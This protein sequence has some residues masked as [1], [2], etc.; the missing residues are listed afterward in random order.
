MLPWKYGMRSVAV[1]A[2]TN[3]LAPCELKLEGKG[4]FGSNKLLN[5]LIAAFE[6]DCHLQ[7]L[8]PTCQL[9]STYSSGTVFPIIFAESA[10][11]PG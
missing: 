8:T 11:L 5:C 3:D 9:Q 10:K 2:S 1:L 7:P 6:T 4:A